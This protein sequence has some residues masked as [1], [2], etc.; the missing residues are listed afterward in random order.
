MLGINWL[1][2][3][4]ISSEPATISVIKAM[5]PFLTGALAAVL[6]PVAEESWFRG[7]LLEIIENGAGRRLAVVV[8]SALFALVHLGGG[9]DQLP[10]L[11]V[12]FVFGLVLAGLR[13]KT[14]GLA[15]GIVAHAI[16][17]AAA[18]VSIYSSLGY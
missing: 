6:A 15:A 2:S 1:M 18:L 10:W 7:R 12:Y 8:T 14:G 5:P 13:L 11:A 16:N 9:L 3:R 17:N 4:W